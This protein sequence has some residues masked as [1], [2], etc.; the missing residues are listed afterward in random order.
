MGDTI[1]LDPRQRH[2]EEFML[3]PQDKNFQGQQ[4]QSQ[5][6]TMGYQQEQP[7]HV[8][9]SAAGQPQVLVWY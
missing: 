2:N 4:R 3:G 8:A 9:G 5:Q 1:T 6:N 7:Q